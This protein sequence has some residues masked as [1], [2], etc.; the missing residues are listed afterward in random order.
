MT[1]IVQEPHKALRTVS[2]PVPVITIPSKKIQDTIDHMHAVLATCED[3]VALAAPQV[4]INM[5][6]FV[7][8]PKAYPHN[9]PLGPLVF[10]N[11]VIIKT[12]GKMVELEEGCLSVR[13]KYGKIERYTEA[14]VE[15]YDER[16][17]K[18]TKSGSGLL[19]QIFQHEIDHLD[20]TLFI[21]KAHSIHEYHPH[22]H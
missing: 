6:I 8:S 16:G 20:A 21:D 5:R 12:S 2:E 13:W 10:I 11:P 18:F 3:G 4:G 15:A 7:V 9:E 19:A 17:R 1:H 14:T 22:Q